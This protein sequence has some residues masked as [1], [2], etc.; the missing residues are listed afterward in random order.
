MSVELRP[1]L[2]R[3]CPASAVRKLV[4]SRVAR[5]EVK[6]TE[7]GLAK[8]SVA[9]SRSIED[10]LVSD[11]IRRRSDSM[12]HERRVRRSLGLRQ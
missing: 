5:I 2:K 4:M 1:G 6:A 11:R 9:M 3:R 12:T 7:E 10:D 8:F